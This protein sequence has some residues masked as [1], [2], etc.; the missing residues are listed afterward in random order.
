[1]SQPEDTHCFPYAPSTRTPPPFAF[2]RFLW[3]TPHPGHITSPR[4]ATSTYIRG[5]I[6]RVLATSGY[7]PN[8]GGR[9]RTRH[10]VTRLVRGPEPGPPST[11]V[12]GYPDNM[13]PRLRSSSGPDK[14]MMGRHFV[15]TTSVKRYQSKHSNAGSSLRFRLNEHRY[16]TFLTSSRGQP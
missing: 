7:P 1:M 16:L 10:R 9:T 2:V 4:P 5:T 8:S 13:W 12:P 6:R 3:R 11:R 15:R 14:W